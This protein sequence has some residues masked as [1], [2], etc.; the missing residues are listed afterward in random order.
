MACPAERSGTGESHS[1]N[2]DAEHG[3]TTT[4]SL[5]A[6]AT[7]GFAVG[8][9]LHLEATAAAALILTILTVAK[10]FEEWLAHWNKQYQ[11]FLWV[12]LPSVP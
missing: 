4:A 3:L 10:P 8:S 9:V 12:E 6:V 5:W 7:T 11:I 1:R 2:L